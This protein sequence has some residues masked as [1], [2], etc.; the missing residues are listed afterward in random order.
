MCNLHVVLINKTTSF[1]N[2]LT[3][4]KSS[5]N[6]VLRWLRPQGQ[7]IFKINGLEGGN[8]QICPHIL[9]MHLPPMGIFQIVKHNMKILMC[10]NI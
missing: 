5:Y 2:N 8:S 10:L 3:S 7:D 4:T 6:L 1:K 9:R